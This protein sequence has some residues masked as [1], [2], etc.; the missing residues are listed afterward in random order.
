VVLRVAHLFVVSA[1]VELGAGSA[2]LAM[3]SL[4]SSL[5]FGSPLPAGTGVAVARVA[6]LALV[7]L[8]LICVL[9]R[10][11]EHSAAAK[12]IIVGLTV[13]NAA[14]ALLMVLVAVVVEL[15]GPL[16]W[17]TVATHAALTVLCVGARRRADTASTLSSYRRRVAPRAR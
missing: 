4:L 5:L 16:L 17:P 2:M 1:I 9:A 13:Y 15:R 14:I 8:G 11:D 7:A 10:R 12:A 6:A 3:P